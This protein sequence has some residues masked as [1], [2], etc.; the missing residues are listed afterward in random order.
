MDAKGYNIIRPFFKPAYKNNT[1]WIHDRAL[2]KIGLL[3]NWRAMTF[4]NKV[5][6]INTFRRSN[7]Q[8][9]SWLPFKLNGGGGEWGRRWGGRAV[10]LSNC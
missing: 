5:N 9:L 1:S 10:E 8:F 4:R 6:G 3:A 2:T 7:V